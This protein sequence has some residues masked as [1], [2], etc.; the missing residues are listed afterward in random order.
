M[1]LWGQKEESL[2][3]DNHISKVLVHFLNLQKAKY[4][5]SDE[6]P[7]WQDKHLHHCFNETF[8]ERTNSWYKFCS[9]TL[10]DKFSIYG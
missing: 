1:V 5:L 9:E 6:V 10:L 3:H 2:F 4:L 7:K 8:N